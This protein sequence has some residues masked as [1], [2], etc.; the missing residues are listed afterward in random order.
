MTNEQT[1]PAND[2]QF[3]NNMVLGDEELEK[4]ESSINDDTRNGH[5][6]M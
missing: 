5:V 4:S 1:Q 6:S 2:P 3:S